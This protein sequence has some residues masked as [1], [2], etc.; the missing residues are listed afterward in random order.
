MAGE[1][2]PFS[3]FNEAS[4]VYEEDPK[5]TF[6]GSHYPRLKC[7]MNKY[8]KRGIFAVAG[9]VGFEEWDKDLNCRRP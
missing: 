9:G 2:T 4:L 8:D 5:K 1:D 6:F 7:I 3:I